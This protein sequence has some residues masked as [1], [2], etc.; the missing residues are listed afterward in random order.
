MKNEEEKKSGA[1]PGDIQQSRQRKMQA[2]SYAP[3]LGAPG[4]TETTNAQGNR[5]F[6]AYRQVPNP[7]GIDVD[8]STGAQLKAGRLPSSGGADLPAIA[9]R[10]RSIENTNAFQRWE[11]PRKVVNAATQSAGL[12]KD[13]AGAAVAVPEDAVRNKTI[14]W[15]GGDPA[16]TTGGTTQEQDRAFSA[17][18]NRLSAFDPSQGIA[19]LKSGIL[20]ATGAQP[21][22]PTKI[23]GSS[24]ANASTNTTNV[25]TNTNTGTPTKE[26][27]TVNANNTATTTSNQSGGIAGPP[28]SLGIQGITEGRTDGRRSF[29]GGGGVGSD[30]VQTIDMGITDA[31]RTGRSG[32]ANPGFERALASGDYEAALQA[33]NRA[34]V[35]QMSRLGQLGGQ[36]NRQREADL[37]ASQA[38][39]AAA[40]QIDP[41]LER[42]AKDLAMQGFSKGAQRVMGMAQQPGRNPNAAG[43]ADMLPNEVAG[44]D[45]ARTNQA[46]AD[47]AEAQ[48]AQARTTQQQQG[49]LQ[50]LIDQMNSPDVTD[51]QRQSLIQRYQ[52]LSGDQGATYESRVVDGYDE[53]NNPTQTLY[54]INQRTGQAQAVRPQPQPQVGAV[55]TSADG[56]KAKLAGYDE[57]GNPKWEAVN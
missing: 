8:I 6:G 28:N 24:T 29:T 17:L 27:E 20:E 37:R 47:V 33:V 4:V 49:I 22:A 41:M 56:T 40:P 52:A 9:D 26:T 55:Y 50:G 3:G 32:I 25:S 38:A 48:A 5:S 16:S 23:P 10:Q 18:Q 15:A 54:T 35:G 12:M 34:D 7:G 44:Y 30:Y 46:N 42:H 31:Q 13:L 53:N 21:V 19:N 36:I 2:S 1:T 39:R 14:E 45:E 57:S 43:I 11:T 51:E